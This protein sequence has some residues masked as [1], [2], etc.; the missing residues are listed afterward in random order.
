V[1]VY[2]IRAIHRDRPS[3]AEADRRERMR[4]LLMISSMPKG[5]NADRD[6]AKAELS[7]LVAE[8]GYAYQPPPEPP[9]HRPVSEEDPDR[10]GWLRRVDAP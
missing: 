2:F 5:V 7:K 6:R 10:P 1:F 8:E 9:L 4:V 3:R